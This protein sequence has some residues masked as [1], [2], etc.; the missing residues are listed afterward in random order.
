MKKRS[1]E[2]WIAGAFDALR[3]GGIEA[4]RVEPLAARLGV[5]KG[6]FYHHF[7]NRRAL[8]LAMLEEWER[9]GT[10]DIIDEVGRSSGEPVEAL[11][12]L[13]H[14]TLAVNPGVDEIE[15]GIR[16]WAVTDDVVA[17]AAERVD[18]RRLDYV[19]SL[20]RA[21]GLP[22]PLARRRARL[23]YRVLIGEFTWRSSGGPAMSKREIDELVDALVADPSA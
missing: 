10:S 18:A 3:D 5:T 23:L 6:S 22:S 4:L 7:D 2:A 16:A 15:L 19:A 8:Y 21:I 9:S 17:A 1:R 14:N 11:R 20:L 13:A 12:R